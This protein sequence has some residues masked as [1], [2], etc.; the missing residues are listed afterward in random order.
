M[1]N[2]ISNNLYNAYATNALGQESTPNVMNKVQSANI[3][4]ATLDTI[5]LT[6]GMNN[7]DAEAKEAIETVQQD[8]SQSPSEALA[9][10]Q[11]LDYNRVMALL[12]DI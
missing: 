4:Q 7:L 2:A 11:G 10:H 8:L 12:G 1:T 5:S 3:N 6:Y 9:V